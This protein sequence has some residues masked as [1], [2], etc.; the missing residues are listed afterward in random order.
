MEDKVTTHMWT[1]HLD[2]NWK[3]YV[4]NYIEEYHIPWIHPETFQLLTPLKHWIEFPELTEGQPWALMVGQNPGLTFSETGDALFPVTPDLKDLEPAYDGMPIWLAYPT[5]MVIPTADAIV[6]Y[7]AYPEGPE[8]TRIQLWLCLPEQAV[9]A[10][11]AGDPEVTKAVEEYAGG[12]EMFIAE[13]NNVCEMQ[14]V[15]LRSRHGTSGRFCK[16]E[17]LAREFDQWVADKAYRV[18]GNGNGNGNGAH[19]RNGAH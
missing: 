18:D 2:C 9:E 16:H 11:K 12:C 17:G 10:W 1:Y 6:Y 5:F 7:V 8:K 4:E 3:T 13:D 15:G 19:K 14:Q